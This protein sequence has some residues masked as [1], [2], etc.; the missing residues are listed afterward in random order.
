MSYLNPITQYSCDF[1]LLLL[2]ILNIQDGLDNYNWQNG[3]IEFYFI[4]GVT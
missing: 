1:F 4:L 3:F 2:L